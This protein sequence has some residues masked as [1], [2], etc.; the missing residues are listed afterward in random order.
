MT[1]FVGRKQQTERYREAVRALRALAEAEGTDIASRAHAEATADLKRAD[2]AR[3]RGVQESGGRPCIGRLSGRPSDH[4]QSD[5]QCNP[6]KGD[7]C[8]LWMKDGR[9]EVFVSQP[10]ELSWAGLQETVA[11]CQANGLR[12][13]VISWPSWHFPGS[14]LTVEYRTLDT[15]PEGLPHQPRTEKESAAGY[16]VTHHLRDVDRYL[17]PFVEEKAP[18]VYALLR[19]RSRYASVQ[20]FAGKVGWSPET[21]MHIARLMEEASLPFMIQGIA[22]GGSQISVGETSA[23]AQCV[24]PDRAEWLCQQL[25]K[26]LGS[27][28]PDAEVEA[29]G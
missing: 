13:D 15:R 27:G 12:A 20:A 4:N 3:S 9:P 23:R 26:I 19:K 18:K 25:A 17:G 24:D 5:H 28:Q 29:S 11:F 6:P 2:W 16:V 10:Y 8:S 21:Q 14:V 22:M 7:H 1:A